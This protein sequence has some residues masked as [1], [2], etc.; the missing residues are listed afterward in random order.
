MYSGQ[1]HSDTVFREIVVGEND[2]TACLITA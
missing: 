1:D 2:Q